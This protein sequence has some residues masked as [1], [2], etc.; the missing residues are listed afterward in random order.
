[1][2][3]KYQYRRA[4]RLLFYSIDMLAD[5]LSK[6]L[7]FRLGFHIP[8]FYS[9]K[10]L[11]LHIL[12]APFKSAFRHAKYPVVRGRAG[13]EKGVSWFVEVEQ[14]IAILEKGGT[15]KILSC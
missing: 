4:G 7:R 15:V 11:H 2:I 6:S 5:A 1:M 12:A 8:P 14:A 13:Y 10:H 9:V 3:S